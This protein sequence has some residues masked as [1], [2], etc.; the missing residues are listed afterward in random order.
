MT[1]ARACDVSAPV[2]FAAGV[3]H[4]WA[5]LA[6]GRRYRTREEARLRADRDDAIMV[7]AVWC[8]ELAFLLWFSRILGL[9]F[10]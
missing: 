10:G 8:V 2:L 9:V 4:A 5:F 6:L 7:R 3:L 1:L